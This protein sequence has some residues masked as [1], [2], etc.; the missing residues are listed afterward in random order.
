MSELSPTIKRLSRFPIKG[1]TAEQLTSVTL[2]SGEGVP[3]DRLYGFARYNSGFDPANPQPLPK[4]RFVVLVNEAKLAG[5]ESHFNQDSLQLEIILSQETHHFDMST[6]EGCQRAEL[7]LYETLSLS[8]KEPPV[9]VSSS[10]HR[11]T[12]VSVDSVE[13]MNA[14]SVLNLTSVHELEKMIDA[15][16]DPARFRANIEI[17]GLPPFSELEAIGST[18]AFSGVELKIVARTKRC[19]AT[20]VNPTSAERDM[21][22]PYLIKNNL[23]HADMG[24]YVSVA[25]GGKLS[26]GQSGM[27]MQ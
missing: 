14:I 15:E 25:S 16:I 22:I 13:M 9:F 3:G 4:Q 7:F 2:S 10:P 17:D 6:P 20:E 19:A 26:I 23:G 5:L 18:L 1:M 11:F 12:D 21:K 24:V 8:D 27:F